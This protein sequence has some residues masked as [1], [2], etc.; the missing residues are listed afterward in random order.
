MGKCKIKNRAIFFDRDGVLNEVKLVKNK[1]HPPQSLNEMR[2]I[3]Q[4]KKL[5]SKLKLLGY[6]F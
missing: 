3:F 4:S 2:L 5:I 6:C 1:P